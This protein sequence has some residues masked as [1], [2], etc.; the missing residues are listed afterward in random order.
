MKDKHGNPQ[1]QFAI[2]NERVK[3]LQEYQQKDRYGFSKT[4]LEFSKLKKDPPFRS[5]KS[6]FLTKEYDFD[7]NTTRER[8]YVY[9]GDWLG[10]IKLWDLTG[11][12]AKCGF[13]KVP[14]FIATKPSFVA[15]RKG[16]I[17]V[18]DYSQKLL[19]QSETAKITLPNS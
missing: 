2:L 18:C 9:T 8:Y 19:K 16:V 15:T 17:D 1:G 13:G 5:V 7:V 12:L 11:V 6:E 10:Y 3:L 4:E 14:S